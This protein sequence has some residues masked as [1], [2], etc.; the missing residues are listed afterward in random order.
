MV[1]LSKGE[2]ERL[3]LRDSGHECAGTGGLTCPAERSSAVALLFD[4]E[5]Q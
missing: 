5:M 1:D 3:G 4:D 2:G